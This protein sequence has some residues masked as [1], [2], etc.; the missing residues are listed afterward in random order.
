MG[1]ARPFF[2]R[3]NMANANIDDRLSIG[4]RYW[5]GFTYKH[6]LAIDIYTTAAIKRTIAPKDVWQERNHLAGAPFRDGRLNGSQLDNI[7]DAGPVRTLDEDGVATTFRHS[8]FSISNRRKTRIPISAPIAIIALAHPLSLRVTTM[9]KPT[10]LSTK[11]ALRA[12]LEVLSFASWCYIPFSLSPHSG[13]P[14]PHFRSTRYPPF[15]TDRTF[16]AYLSC[17]WV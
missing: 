16:Y 1:H 7:S 11:K 15:Y 8:D 5:Q 3:Y 4:S 6:C 13:S 2:P 14:Y 12:Y 10:V 9:G 17:V